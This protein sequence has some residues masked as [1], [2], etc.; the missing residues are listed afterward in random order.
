LI[1][2]LRRL[3]RADH[4][5]NAQLLVHLCEV[6]ARGLY[7]EHA[8]ASMYT[9]CVAELHMSEA[10]AYLRINAA[11]SGR[12]FTRILQLV[13]QGAVHLTA[14]KL[15]GPH[16]RPDNHEQLLECARGKGKREVEL[17]VATLAPK[18]DVPTRIRKLRQRGSA[19][20]IATVAMPAPTL[21]GSLIC[22]AR[23]ETQRGRRELRPSEAACGRSC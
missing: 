15:L 9:Y 7:R 8:H 3:A 17:L 20:S 11:R 12:K 4:E 5:L 13:A 18:P 16:L 2:A 21:A 1:T 22:S 23:G 6:E 14:I 19:P 10:Q